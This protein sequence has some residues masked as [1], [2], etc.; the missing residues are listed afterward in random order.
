MSYRKQR[1]ELKKAITRHLSIDIE[2]CITQSDV[3][4]VE[5]IV[6]Q[7]ARAQTWRKFQ[8]SYLLRMD[9]NEEGEEKD[10]IAQSSREMVGTPKKD[11]V[12]QDSTTSIASILSESSLMGGNVAL[13]TDHIREVCKLI[14]SPSPSSKLHAIDILNNVSNYENL[15]ASGEWPVLEEWIRSLLLHPSTVIKRETLRLFWTML[16][17][18]GVVFEQTYT[19]LLHAARDQVCQHNSSAP[20][21][22]LHGRPA[23]PVDVVE[24]L[25]VYHRNLPRQWLRFPRK[26]IRHVIEQALALM[27]DSIYDNFSRIWKSFASADTQATWLGS[28]LHGAESRA[29]VFECLSDHTNILLHALQLVTNY[30]TFPDLCQRD[31]ASHVYAACVLLRV[32]MY[33]AGRELFDSL[34]S[35]GNT[36][37]TWFDV[38]IKV[39]LFSKVL[40]GSKFENFPLLLNV[41]TRAVSLICS[42]TE[43]PILPQQAEALIS[44]L[45]DSSRSSSNGQCSTHILSECLGAMCLS[46]SGLVLITNCTYKACKVP[47]II[48]SST[49]RAIERRSEHGLCTRCVSNFLRASGRIVQDPGHLLSG[50]CAGVVRLLSCASEL[51]AV[52]DEE[53]KKSLTSFVKALLTTS[54]GTALLCVG[55]I[56]E[57][58][59]KIVLEITDVSEKVKYCTLHM[60]SHYSHND[61]VLCAGCCIWSSKHEL[62]SSPERVQE[63]LL[64][65]M[66]P[67]RQC[68][69]LLGRSAQDSAE[70]LWNAV[71]LLAPE[72]CLSE[73]HLVVALNVLKGLVCC[74]KT[75]VFLHAKYCVCQKLRELI[76]DFCNSEGKP[77][78]CEVTLKANEVE[79]KINSFSRGKP[80]TLPQVSQA[81]TG[82]KK[83]RIIGLKYASNKKEDFE[84]VLADNGISAAGF[85]DIIDFEDSEKDSILSSTRSLTAEQKHGVQLTVE[86]GL[87]L[88]LLSHENEDHAKNLEKLIHNGRHYYGSSCSK[89]S[90]DFLLATI[91]LLL[92]GNVTKSSQL[93]KFLCDRDCYALYFHDM[94]GI[95]DTLVCASFCQLFVVILRDQLPRLYHAFKMYSY[96]PSNVLKHWIG[97]FF[98]EC[99]CFDEIAA[100]LLM[101]I[102]LGAE[103]L[104]YVCLSMLKHIEE[105]ALQAAN[106]FRFIAMLRETEMPDFKLASYVEY[107]KSLLEEYGSM[108]Q[109]SL[110]MYAH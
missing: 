98:W 44:S 46:A 62:R 39:V 12:R 99:L 14:R 91:F 64:H 85:S 50:G 83:A 31:T 79:E 13:S 23:G 68:K 38:F 82:Q 18:G 75:Y 54:L 6:A 81:F 61:L 59:E 58:Y 28:W 1:E 100:V 51:T 32:L 76:A 11:L 43:S 26:A 19:S 106:E 96:E 4:T 92:R 95:C 37:K 67:F 94:G 49:K 30:K 110:H 3:R 89:D 17:S 20:S 63:Q 34:S 47:Q 73:E 41:M 74:L 2:Q 16:S 5:H 52:A 103:T 40:W 56:P 15:V 24:L 97:Q 90:Y 108:V 72:Q 21:S 80:L 71:T 36:E 45:V 66:S 35:G 88:G 77:I 84:A 60:P 102:T 70:S 69:I 7:V 78:I 57:A 42:L 104:L 48:L 105:Q 65:M 33:R 10:F 8:K 29:V 25:N 101:V 87:H 86:C 27:D 109:K 53:L 9:P 55:T 107:I 22:K 93:H